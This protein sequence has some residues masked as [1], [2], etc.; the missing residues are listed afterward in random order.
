MQGV[1][2]DEKTGSVSYFSGLHIDPGTG[3]EYEYD[4]LPVYDGFIGET[5]ILLRPLK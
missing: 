3:E 4:Y 1:V 2:Y 5:V